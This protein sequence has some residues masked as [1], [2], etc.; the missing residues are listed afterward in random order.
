MA[1]RNPPFVSVSHPFPHFLGCRCSCHLLQAYN[2]LGD[3]LQPIMSHFVPNF[4]TNTVSPLR[5]VFFSFSNIQHTSMESN[6]KS[7]FSCDT[8]LSSAPHRKHRVWILS[9]SFFQ[10]CFFSF[11]LWLHPCVHPTTCR[12]RG[13]GDFDEAVIPDKPNWKK[14]VQL[15]SIY[16][17]R[18]DERPLN[19]FP[20][21][22]IGNE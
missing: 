11:F 3:P 19:K 13:V 17:Y 14:C 2:G 20:I 7:N 22:A 12:S 15:F 18:A 6:D 9:L 5:R 10:T 1:N 8:L 21:K 16:T 4:N